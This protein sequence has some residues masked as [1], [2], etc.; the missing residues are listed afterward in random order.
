MTGAVQ[1]PILL[2]MRS[3]EMQDEITPL[4]FVG[5]YENVGAFA[6]LVNTGTSAMVR[7]FLRFLKFKSSFNRIFR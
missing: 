7:N 2:E 3:S 5:H 6:E 4:E 1:S